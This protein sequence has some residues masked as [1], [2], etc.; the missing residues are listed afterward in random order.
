MFVFRVLQKL[1]TLI[2]VVVVVAACYFAKPYSVFSIHPVAMIC[3]LA[4]GSEAL[5]AFQSFKLRK[6]DHGKKRL[7]MMKQIDTHRG[8]AIIS[9]FML[10]IGFG[11]IYSAKNYKHK[12]HFESDHAFYGGIL[13]AWAVSQLIFGG[14]AFNLKFPRIMHKAHGLSG[15]I[16]L[17]TATAFT[18]YTQIGK[19]TSW[20]ASASNGIPFSYIVPFRLIAVGALIS[21]CALMGLNYLLNRRGRA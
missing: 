10:L 11:A 20:F 9:V 21:T 18:A 1:S 6:K 14:L 4:L 7:P 19:P 5:L 12:P 2:M 16:L 8:A 17:M 15:V 3:F 13:V